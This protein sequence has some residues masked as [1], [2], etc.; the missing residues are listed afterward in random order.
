[1]LS[2]AVAL[3]GLDLVDKAL[4][5]AAHQH[6]RSTFVVLVTTLIVLGLVVTV[7]RIASRA[8]FAGAAIAVGGALGNLVAAVLWTHGVP[9]PLVAGNS[10]AG[11]AFS[12]ADVFIFVGD[13]TMVSAVLIYA[14][15][16]RAALRT[17]V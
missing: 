13:A 1:M 3:A 2:I 7:P 14:L 11:I 16:H 12:L 4:T 10:S 6:A 17:S 9:D 15:R 5:H 8:A